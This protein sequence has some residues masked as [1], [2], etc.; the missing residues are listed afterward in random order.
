MYINVAHKGALYPVKLTYYI[1]EYDTNY[2]NVEWELIEGEDYEDIDTTSI[3]F[4][5]KV[6]ST[7]FMRVGY[8]SLEGRVGR[9]DEDDL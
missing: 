4:G 2:I 7:A 5:E 8:R 3:D 9:M 6:R 1:C